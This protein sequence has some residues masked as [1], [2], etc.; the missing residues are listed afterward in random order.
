VILLAF[1]KEFSGKLELLDL[2]A[3]RTYRPLLMRCVVVVVGLLIAFLAGLPIASSAFVAAGLLLVSRIR[4][5]K[6]LSLDWELLAFFSGLFIVTGAIEATGLSAQ[7][8]AIA[9]PVLHSGIAA[10]SVV[11]AA[12]SNVVSNVPAVLLFRSE[13]PNL[14]NPQQGWLTLAMASTLAGNLTLLGSVANLIVAEIAHSRGVELSFGA[15]LR[16]GVPVTLLTISVGV[17]W[18]T[19]SPLR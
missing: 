7:L 10:L 17:L 18:L 6:L 12:L 9:A 13:I 2:P 5:G 16:V 3:P 19:F 8:F 14:P 11:T 4:P 15:Y 1:P